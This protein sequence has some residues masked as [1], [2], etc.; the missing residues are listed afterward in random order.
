MTNPAPAI[1]ALLLTY[2][3]ESM[4]RCEPFTIG[5]RKGNRATVLLDDEYV[6]TLHARFWREDGTWWVEDMGSTNGTRRLPVQPHDMERWGPMP[7]RKGDRFLI[8]HTH[9]TAVPA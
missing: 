5:S 1:P 4:V 3:T 9:I 2:G 7:I 8:G 6:S